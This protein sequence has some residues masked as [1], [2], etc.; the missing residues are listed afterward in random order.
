LDASAC[1]RWFLRRA[2]GTSLNWSKGPPDTEYRPISVGFRGF[3]RVSSNRIKDL[4]TRVEKGN[5]W[6]C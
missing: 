6:T 5:G 4:Q 2:L 1:N 3:S